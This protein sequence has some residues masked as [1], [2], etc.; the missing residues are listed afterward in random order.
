MSWIRELLSIFLTDILGSRVCDLLGSG[1]QGFCVHECFMK[2]GVLRMFVSV[3]M[4]AG[5][6]VLCITHP[7]SEPGDKLFNSREISQSQD[8]LGMSQQQQQQCCPPKQQCC[9][10]QQ[11]YCPPQQQYCPPQQQCCP[12]QQ[13]CCP[14]QQQTKQ[15]CQPPPKCTPKCAPAPCQQ[16]CPPA[17]KCQ[18][19]KQK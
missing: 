17:Q 6:H 13:Q 2:V 3:Q 7:Y 19:S 15:P 12:P 1:M 9:P 16:K 5:A 18:K 11:Q 8:S 4:Y 14:P 10:P